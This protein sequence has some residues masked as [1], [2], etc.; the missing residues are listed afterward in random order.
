MF[1]ELNFSIL[2]KKKTKIKIFN[3]KNL[4]NMYMYIAVK[5]GCLEGKGSGQMSLPP[6]QSLTD[7]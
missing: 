3:E 1:Q 2:K 6:G 4:R 5:N 7:P